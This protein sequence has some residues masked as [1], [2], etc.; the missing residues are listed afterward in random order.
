M[1]MKEEFENKNTLDDPM[2]DFLNNCY[3][4]TQNNLNKYDR[5]VINNLDSQM[6]L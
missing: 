4:R 2:G 3:F 5:I 6:I 1:E